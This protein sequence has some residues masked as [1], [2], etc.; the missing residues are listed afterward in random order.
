MGAE[1]KRAIT[2]VTLVA[3]FASTLA[4]PSIHALV[5]FIG[6][7]RTMWVLAAVVSLV[8]TPLI[9]FAC[10]TAEQYSNS[11]Q[12]PA[13]PAASETLHVMQ[14]ATFW[15]L[16]VGFVMIALNH[17]SLLTHLLPLLNERGIE[18]GMAIFAASMIGPMQVTGRLIMLAVEKHISSLYMFAACFLAMGIASVALLGTNTLPF[19]LI[20]FV[21]FQGAGYGATSI[22]RPVVIAELLGEKNFGLIA[23]FLALPYLAA[24][25][26]APTIAALLWQ[27]GGYDVVIAFAGGA[28]VVGLV[29]LLGAATRSRRDGTS[30]T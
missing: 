10:Q 24:A 25:A 7:R 5:G 2:V 23:G 15:L 13:S 22:M 18:S 29:A 4:F 27:V 3:G 9:W 20:G 1:R 28:S 30:K 12:S 17:G 14:K 16:A 21:V 26:A 8:A 6:W 11:D 19:L